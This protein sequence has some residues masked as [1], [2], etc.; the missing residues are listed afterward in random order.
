[1]TGKGLY[2]TL[3]ER[4]R[5]NAYDV[6]TR[7]AWPDRLPEDCYWM[8]P[9]LLTV[10]GTEWADGIG[11]DALMRL[12]RLETINLFSIFTRGES[13]LL[14]T[15]LQHCIRED[16]SDCFDYFSHFID[17]EN[18]H[19]W[20]FAEFC[21]RYR[22]KP[23]PVKMLK[24]VSGFAPEAELFLAFMRILVFEEMGDFLN[25]QVMKDARV[26][27]LLREIHRT[28]HQDESGH[29]AMGW[30][31]GARLWARAARGPDVGLKDRIRAYLDGY[32]AWSVQNLYNPQVYADAGFA[33]PYKLREKLL[34]HPARRKWQES[35]FRRMRNRLATVLEPAG[36]NEEISI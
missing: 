27:E 26:P 17:E 13:E 15:V 22:G 29:I 30:S 24:G 12:S 19:M 20:F 35:V 3:S 2:Q 1:M 25:V 32:A 7:F 34:E 8:G 18:K 31:V 9:E 33:E 28:H 16:L 23:Y 6:Y 10:A 11:E 14:Q 21:R 5:A 36:Q 4:S